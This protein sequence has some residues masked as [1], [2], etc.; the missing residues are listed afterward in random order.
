MIDCSANFTKGAQ[1]EQIPVTYNAD[2]N[3]LKA[4]VTYTPHLCSSIAAPILITRL[5]SSPLLTDLAWSLFLGD[6]EDD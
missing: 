1:E 2:T 5:A 4:K 3:T 6:D